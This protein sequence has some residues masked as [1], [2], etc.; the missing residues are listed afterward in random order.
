MRVGW[1]PDPGEGG[2]KRGE[3]AVRSMRLQGRGPTHVCLAGQPTLRT[4]DFF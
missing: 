2:G 1:S 4:L 3:S